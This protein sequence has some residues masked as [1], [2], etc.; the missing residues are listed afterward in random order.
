MRPRPQMGADRGKPAHEAQKTEPDKN[1]YLVFK[2]GLKGPDSSYDYGTHFVYQGQE[3]AVT[4]DGQEAGLHHARQPRCGRQ[5]P[6]DAARV[7]GHQRTAHRRDRRLDM[8]P[9]AKRFDLHN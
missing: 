2:D 8:G 9:W 6:G 4:V 7:P 1:T 5:A 3:L